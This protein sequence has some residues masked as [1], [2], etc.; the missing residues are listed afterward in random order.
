M[1]TTTNFS[2]T[3]PADTDLVK[4]GAAAIRTLGSAIDTSFVDLKGGTTGQV[5]SKASN[6]D[7]DYSWITVASGGM[8]LLSSSSASSVGTVTFSTID[9]TYKSLLIWAEG[10]TTSTGTN[11][12]FRVNGVTS[13]S[14]YKALFS[15]NNAYASN[16]T[17]SWEQVVQHQGTN[18]ANIQIEI[19]NYTYSGSLK[20]MLNNSSGKSAGTTAATAYNSLCY[21]YQGAITSV[22]LILDTGTW[23]A[24][25]VYLYGVK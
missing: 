25:T 7:L 18:I 20:V 11:A 21:I 5:L 12:N 6:T 2:W 23:T 1:P 22:S 8:T 9:Q 24:G 17:T 4:D 15:E 10:L 3:T 14:Y 19:P 16:G 13:S